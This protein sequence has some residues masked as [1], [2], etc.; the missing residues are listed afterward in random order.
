MPEFAA[1][2]LLSEEHEISDFACGQPSLDEFLKLHALA[3]QNAMLSRTYVVTE[4]SAG[5]VAYYTLA[6]ISVQSEE[7]PKRLARGMPASIPAILLARLAID[8]RFQGQG[9][10]RSLF[11]DSLMRTWAV[12]SGHVPVR[13]FVVD[14]ID[15]PARE[16]YEKLGMISSPSNP[17]RLF[18]HYKDIRAAVEP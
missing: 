15:E 18:L 11:A 13:I 8:Q 12:M 9:L 10:G 5:V 3:K 14:A 16:F 7:A 6:H 2:V 1:P 4:M 17:M